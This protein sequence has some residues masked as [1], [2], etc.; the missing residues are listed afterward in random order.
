MY[1]ALKLI[2]QSTGEHKAVDWRTPPNYLINK[3]PVHWYSDRAV[4][5][6]L[7]CFVKASGTL[8]CGAFHWF[9]W[10]LFAVTRK[11]FS[12]SLPFDCLCWWRSLYSGC[13]TI[14]SAKHS[15][16]G[17]SIQALAYL[18][19]NVQFSFCLVE[20]AYIFSLWFLCCK[21]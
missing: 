19:T 12:C 17:P 4:W 9:F 3:P 8:I 2:S 5:N 6:M 21:N 15:L 18:R 10:N 13:L 16:S 11:C 20:L 1:S 14:E 7:C